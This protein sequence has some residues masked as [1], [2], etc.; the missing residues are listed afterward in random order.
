MSRYKS[1]PAFALGLHFTSMTAADP[2][3]E[4]L[5]LLNDPS[6]WLICPPVPIFCA[7]QRFNPDGSIKFEVIDRD[8]YAIVETTR[9]LETRNGVLPV[10]TLGAHRVPN[11]PPDQQPDIV[12]FLRNMQVGTWGPTGRL[13]ILA[14]PW[15]YPARWE[16]VKQYPFRSPEY[17]HKRQTITGLALLKIDPELD[18]GMTIYF[19]EGVDYYSRQDE[20]TFFERLTM[21]EE[22]K[23]AESKELPA[24]AAPAASPA[25]TTSNEAPPIDE[26]AH[27]KL[28]PHIEHYMRQHFGRHAEAYMR[29]AHPHLY[30]AGP[31]GAPSGTNTF[32]PAATSVV[33]GQPQERETEKKEV[34]RMERE[35]QA[36]LYQKQEERIKVLEDQLKAETYSRVLA[37]SEQQ[38]TQLEAQG[39]IIP[40]RVIDG[41]ET[42]GRVWMVN[43]LASLATE[44]ERDAYLAEARECYSR[45]PVPLTPPPGVSGNG[46]IPVA[47][48]SPD[49]DHYRNLSRRAISKASAEKKTYDQAL[50]ELQESAT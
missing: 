40:K 23:K 45:L 6:R 42:A 10:I 2:T 25:G 30:A 19:R 39:I 15:Y 37:R 49:E 1:D 18:M 43:K 5:R 46:A 22:I 29:Q 20:A 32:T 47:K 34:Q 41:K 48:G 35:E 7:H 26:A 44:A 31:G 24:P 36:I 28:A 9:G 8:L 21:A 27:A 13:G 16:E 12:G 4:S 11:V 38:V 3:L 33:A 14:E 17:Y 50:K